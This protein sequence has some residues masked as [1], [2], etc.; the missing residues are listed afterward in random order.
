[1]KVLQVLPALDSGGVERGTVDFG[2][3][4]VAAGHE[5]LVMSSGGAMVAQLEGEGSRHIGFPVHRKSLLSLRHV[6]P[7]RRLLHELNPD[8]VHVRSR[9]PAWLVWL[10][11]RNEPDRPA[12]V[13]TFHGLYSVNR[14]S[15]IMGA[16]DAVIAISDCVRDYIVSSYPQIDA[17]KITVIHRGVDTRLFNPDKRPRQRWRDTF[18]AEHPNLSGQTLLTMP[19][20]LTRWKGQA[21]FI[22]LIKALR[23]QGAQVHGL[24]VG[25]PSPGK[26]N[27]LR[28]LEQQVADEKL[29][30][31]ITFLG[32]R[33]D[34]ENILGASDIVFNLSRH[35]EPFGRTVIEA[36]AMGVP[37]IAYD[38]GGPA[39]SLHSSLPEGLV[40]A[41]D[42]G[43]LI[44]VTERFIAQRPSVSF[45]PR[46]T[47]RR[48]TD[49]TLAV[50]QRLLSSRQHSHGAAHDH[51]I[52]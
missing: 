52:R 23:G 35:P 5:S 51:A 16:G 41:G 34:M 7:L 45:D 4:L 2:R 21:E 11:L 32:H 18:F 8:I 43:A 22:E 42:R 33:Q 12:L 27:Y 48:Q 40:P 15:A 17:G 9:L 30:G 37:V 10:A 20:R 3:E 39:E 50:Y 31:H 6:R 44:A 29:G 24:I 49:A 47:L 46:F 38:C 26:E 28:E 1:M 14:Y 13:S 19:G 36:L 25:G